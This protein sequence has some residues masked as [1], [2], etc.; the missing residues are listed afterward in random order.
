[1]GVLGC[2]SPH[3]DS[4]SIARKHGRAPRTPSSE[5]GLSQALVNPLPAARL[6][7]SPCATRH[8]TQGCPWGPPA[9]P[10]SA[11][12]SSLPSVPPAPSACWAPSS[13][14]MSAGKQ[15]RCWG[16]KIKSAFFFLFTFIL[17]IKLI[18]I[19]RGGVGV[20][21]L[22]GVVFPGDAEPREE[23]DA[24]NCDAAAGW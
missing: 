24:P 17:L 10:S 4:C 9:W 19:A 13:P 21:L 18:K 22:L 16:K 14:W 15:P 20:M 5:V 11:A 2:F 8:S 23:G 1:M 7:K 3:I 6:Y 12:S